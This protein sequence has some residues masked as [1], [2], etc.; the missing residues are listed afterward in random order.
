MEIVFK[1]KIVLTEEDIEDLMSS[2]IE[3][4]GIGYWTT[5]DNTTDAWKDRP[6]DE[7]LAE[8][9]AK[10]IL[11]GKELEFIIDDD[12]TVRY[13]NFS[14]L[15]RGIEMFIDGGYDIYGAFVGMD[16]DMGQIDAERADIIIQLALFDDI[17]YG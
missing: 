16:V 5:L 8:A 11:D 6:K 17:I 1:R 12:R 15:K 4:G 7:C 2:A 3:S 13:L 14:N 10:I 9:A